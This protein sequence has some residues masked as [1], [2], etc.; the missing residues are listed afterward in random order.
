MNI[1]W[2]V[3]IWNSP[4][5]RWIYG[6]NTFQI[7]DQGLKVES[8]VNIWCDGL[9]CLSRA[10]DLHPREFGLY[11]K[12]M[13]VIAKKIPPN[14]VENLRDHWKGPFTT[15][16]DTK[17]AENVYK[18]RFQR[19][20]RS[21]SRIGLGLRN[22]LTHVDLQILNYGSIQKPSIKRIRLPFQ[23]WNSRIFLNLL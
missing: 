11:H 21:G 3:A 6:K 22:G 14:P 5:E 16:Q 19:L 13:F 10:F 8:G 20:F 18:F 7:S 17:R 23:R 4:I 2:R 1:A 12:F 15:S 9:Y